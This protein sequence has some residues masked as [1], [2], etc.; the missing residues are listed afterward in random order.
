MLLSKFSHAK[1]IIACTR[2]IIC[3]KCENNNMIDGILNDRDNVDD[4]EDFAFKGSYL[5]IAPKDI[6]DYTKK[7]F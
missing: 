3:N 4:Q 5:K 7:N 2:T 1:R 6:Y